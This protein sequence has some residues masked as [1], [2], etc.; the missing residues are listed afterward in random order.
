MHINEF[1]GI[2]VD[3]WYKISELIN[4]YFNGEPERLIRF[5]NV[6]YKEQKPVTFM[7]PAVNAD[8]R[9]A[10]YNLEGSRCNGND[11]L[12]YA[13]WCGMCLCHN[14]LSPREQHEATISRKI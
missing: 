1:L 11:L 12:I 14:P 7:M 10:S 4:V 6:A 13:D 2:K 3:K 5:I 9:C 8:W